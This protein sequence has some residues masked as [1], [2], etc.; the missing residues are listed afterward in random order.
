MS[1]LSPENQSTVRLSFR[2]ILL[3][4]ILVIVIGFIGGAFSSAFFSASNQPLLPEQD[5]LVTT[6]QEVTVSPGTQASS[7]VDK[8]QSSI[9]L[10]TRGEGTSIQ[11]IGTAFAVTND[12]L[13]M[14]APTV[15]NATHAYDS[16]GQRIALDSVGPDSVY[17]FMYYRIRD[18]VVTPL[19]L[20]GSDA[21]VGAHGMVIS[22]NTQTIHPY[23]LPLQLSRFVL[24]QP[25]TP[26]GIQQLVQFP[27]SLEAQFVGAPVLDESGKLLAMVSDRETGTSFSISHIQASL[28]R[29]TNNQREYNPFADW[30]ITLQYD[31]R[32]NPKNN[33]ALA[34]T[35][36][37]KSVQPDSPAARSGIKVG[38]IIQAI[39]NDTVS[40]EESLTET[41]STREP[42]EVTIVRGDLTQTITMTYASPTPSAP[43]S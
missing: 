20:A 10:L 32:F 21:T 26:P 37:V 35:V 24:P 15:I 31:F 13:L 27:A 43:T 19:D 30:G 17:G 36:S 34:F 23:A 18:A 9:F 28:S 2:W 7:V 6:V 4:L 38:D 12:G 39:N 41:L 25:T 40:W 8:H 22:H 11:I 14:T 3:F 33:N 42:L 1:T 5:R 29:L 16:T